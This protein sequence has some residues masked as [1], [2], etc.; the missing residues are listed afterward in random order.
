MSGEGA[1]AQEGVAGRRTFERVPMLA[2]LGG[3]DF[4]LVWAG[5]GVSLFG[6][7]FHLVALAALVLAMTGSGLALGAI[8]LAASIPRGLFLLIGGALSDRIRPRDLALASN[9]VRAAVTTLIAGLVLG[10]RVEL[11]QLAAAGVVFGTVDAVFLPAINTLIPRLVPVDR[12]A[13]ANALMLGTAQLMGTVGPAVAGFAVAL[14][15]PGA[16]FAL[17]AAS[18][19][20]AALALWLVRGG[21]TATLVGATEPAPA[22]AAP[23]AT[24]LI[25][26]PRLESSAI[27]LPGEGGQAGPSILGSIVSGTR[28]VLGEPVMRSI[29]IISTA[30]NLA[31]TGPSV[32]GLPW[33]VLVHFDAGP[34][35]L[36]LV[37]AAFGA[38]SLVGV[39]AAGSLGRPRRLGFVVLTLV[40]LM[41]LGLAAVGLAPSVPVLALVSAVT[42]AISGYVNVV[43]IAWAQARADPAMLGRTMSFLM[44]G[45]VIAAPLSLVIASAV[46]DT[47]ATELFVLA[48]A[49]VVM[50]GLYGLATGVAKRMT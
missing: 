36:G 4:R 22:Q 28:T 49:L 18:F 26:D 25:A 43:V 44:L 47:Y 17:D 15:G 6:D 27:E 41:G 10:A 2:P 21:T 24:E 50:T 31:F 42:G 23:A 16:A 38:G 34:V 13:A 9:V 46:V 37:F 19:A 48:G 29:V 32:V 33:L 45:G 20:V 39:V 7:Q 30:A 3:R 35:A 11:W 14:V 12:L 8:L 40:L 5:E 1:V